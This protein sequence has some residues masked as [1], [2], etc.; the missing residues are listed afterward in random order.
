MVSAIVHINLHIINML[1]E[2]TVVVMLYA[3]GGSCKK[4][5]MVE[6]VL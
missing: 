6:H 5:L 4:D 2:S 1:I 3:D